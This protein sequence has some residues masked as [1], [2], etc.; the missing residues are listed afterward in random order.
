MAAP[1]GNQFARGKGTKTALQRF[2]EKCAFDPFTGCVMW[3]GGTTHGHG[4][5]SPYGS[6]WDAGRRWFAHRWAAHHIHGLD[7]DGKPVGH[8]CPCGPSTLCVQHL[9]GM[10]REENQEMIKTNPGRVNQDIETRRYWVYVAVGLEEYRPAEREVPDDFP[11]HEPPAW[12]V[13]FMPKAEVF[14]DCPF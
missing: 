5:C 6:F 8:N 11:F 7:I 12:L 2:A 14:D 4:N 9:A 13:P 1:K 10:T 3:I